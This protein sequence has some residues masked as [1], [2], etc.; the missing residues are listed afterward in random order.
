L[1]AAL[2][3]SHP[4]YAGTAAQAGSTPVA[5]AA[6]GETGATGET[7]A[8]SPATSAAPAPIT[9][10]SEWNEAVGF[11]PAVVLPLGV[12]GACIGAFIAV[13]RD[14]DKARRIRGQ[15]GGH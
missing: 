1:G 5:T 9:G 11:F 12:L 14:S 8:Y 7:T 10:G 3:G 15:S 4:A 13:R 6:A 2:F